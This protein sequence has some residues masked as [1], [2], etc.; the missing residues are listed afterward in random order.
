ML[1]SEHEKILTSNSAGARLAAK[2]N[3]SNDAKTAIYKDK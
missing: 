3:E 2:H 1:K